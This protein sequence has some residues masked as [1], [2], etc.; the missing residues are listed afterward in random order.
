MTEPIDPQ[1][2]GSERDRLAPVGADAGPESRTADAGMEF[3]TADADDAVPDASA[4]IA[5]SGEASEDSADAADGDDPADG[6]EA[7]DRDVAGDGDVAAA[8]TVADDPERANG[9]VAAA[10]AELDAAA[11]W[12]PEDQVSAFTAAHE[13]LQATL[14]RIDDH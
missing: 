11:D 14:A 10:L 8:D 13:T 3:R 5:E 4:D 6:N 7:A 1:R 9:Q 12:P 2:D